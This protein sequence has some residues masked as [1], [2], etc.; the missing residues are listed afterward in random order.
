[1]YYIK[2]NLVHKLLFSMGF[3]VCLWVWFLM[4]KW[5]KNQTDRKWICDK[6]LQLGAKIRNSSVYNEIFKHTWPSQWHY[7]NDGC[8][9]YTEQYWGHTSKSLVQPQVLG[10]SETL[11]LNPCQ[12]HK[13]FAHVNNF[14]VVYRVL[15]W[16]SI[17]CS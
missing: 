4:C 16:V 8:L 15:A 13:A 6:M 17:Y 5:K 9:K 14:W 1:M 11:L 10:K 12:G 7:W 3:F 2:C